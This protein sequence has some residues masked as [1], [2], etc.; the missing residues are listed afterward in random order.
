VDLDGHRR[1]DN[2]N[3]IVDI[4][5]YEYIRRGVVFSSY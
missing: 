4:G 3:R 1:I 2:F 5:A